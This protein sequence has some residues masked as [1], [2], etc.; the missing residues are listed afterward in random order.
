M[1]NIS[2]LIYCNLLL[3]AC[4]FF[5]LIARGLFNDFTRIFLITLISLIFVI[6]ICLEIFLILNYP[7]LR[8]Y[9][10]ISAV[11]FA[12]SSKCAVICSRYVAHL[13]DPL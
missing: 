3:F 6:R 10:G 9:I 5:K 12:M 1:G 2:N 11:I 8:N 7:P 4:N 13:S